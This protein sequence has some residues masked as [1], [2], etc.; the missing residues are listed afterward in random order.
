MANKADDEDIS[1]TDDPKFMIRNIRN[2]LI[3]E[4]DFMGLGDFPITD[5]WK[6]YRQELRDLMDNVSPEYQSGTIN[7]VM[8]GKTGGCNMI[9]GVTFPTPPDD[10]LKQT[11]FPYHY[12]HVCYLPED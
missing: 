4:T 12:D 7:L 9:K 6:A 2:Y 11:E 10:A 3:K 5:A 8:T 1:K